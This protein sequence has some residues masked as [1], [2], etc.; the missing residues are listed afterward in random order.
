M[1]HRLQETEIQVQYIS[2]VGKVGLV[3][4]SMPV[5]CNIFGYHQSTLLIPPVIRSVL[6]YRNM[7]RDFSGGWKVIAKNR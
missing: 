5:R 2:E 7:E 1:L 4:A 6:T 3:R